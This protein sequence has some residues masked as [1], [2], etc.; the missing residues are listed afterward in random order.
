[1]FFV[2]SQ[3]FQL[4]SLVHLMV[5]LST[6]SFNRHTIHSSWKVHECY[7]CINFFFSYCL[8]VCLSFSCDFL[9]HPCIFSTRL[10]P[11]FS[12]FVFSLFRNLLLSL[13]LY[14]LFFFFFL[15]VFDSECFYNFGCYFSAFSMMIC[16]WILMVKF[17][18]IFLWSIF[19][20]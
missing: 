6:Y 5:H 13:S 9:F 15:N 4:E 8:L 19:A 17:I 18:A 14:L 2:M 16:S 7:R 11:V 12:L 3:T 1:M 20:I 10:F